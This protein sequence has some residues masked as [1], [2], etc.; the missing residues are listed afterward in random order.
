MY[1]INAGLDF[2]SKKKEVRLIPH[3]PRDDACQFQNIKR[4][5]FSTR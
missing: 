5:Y 3:F 4:T 1:F 2:W